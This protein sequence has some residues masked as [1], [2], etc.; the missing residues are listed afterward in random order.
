MDVNG[1]VKFCE[2]F[3]K[4]WGGP[5]RGGGG[6]SKGWGRWVMLGVGDVNQE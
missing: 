4:K 3:K 2:K 5:I 1:E 6:G